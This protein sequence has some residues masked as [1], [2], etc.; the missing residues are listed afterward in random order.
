MTINIILSKCSIIV[1]S[2]ILRAHYFM[3]PKIKKEKVYFTPEMK[4]KLDHFVK[5][6]AHLPNCDPKKFSMAT[7]YQREWS[8]KWICTGQYTITRFMDNSSDKSNFVNPICIDRHKCTLYFGWLTRLLT[9]RGVYQHKI[10]HRVGIQ[11]PMS[12]CYCNGWR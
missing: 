1:T 10:Q 3:I 4:R 11:I 9:S 7:K 2:R 8:I 12:A 6:T 5:A